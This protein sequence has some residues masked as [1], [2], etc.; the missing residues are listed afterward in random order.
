MFR[1]CGT[2]GC[3]KRDFHKGL[4][5]FEEEAVVEGRSSRYTTGR[6][7][8]VAAPGSSAVDKDVLN[9]EGAVVPF[10]GPVQPAWLVG[11]PY[12]CLKTKAAVE[13]EDDVE[14]VEDEDDEE[15]VEEV[16]EV[17][18]VEEVEANILS[19]DALAALQA[20]AADG[21]E[22]QRSSCLAGYLGVHVSWEPDCT[23][24]ARE[25]NTFLPGKFGT[26]EEAALARARH[27]RKRKNA[28]SQGQ[29][30]P[31]K[32][33]HAPSKQSSVEFGGH[34]ADP[35]LPEKRPRT[36]PLYG[37]GQAKQKAQ[38]LMNASTF[39]SFARN[40]MKKRE[41][42]TGLI[43]GVTWDTRGVTPVLSLTTAHANGLDSRWW[44]G[45]VCSG[46][47]RSRRRGMRAL[48]VSST[49]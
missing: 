20:A 49:Q 48:F 17:V 25:G 4:C 15:E 29:H 35:E 11:L 19:P 32:A 12:R 21:L 38:S 16:E 39:L 40:L 30:A 26:A 28:A 9:A 23:Y 5:S 7:L 43:P 34:T 27:F 10:K 45:C 44:Q 31:S 47:L 46:R 41:S 14:D 3:T 37:A 2:P 1:K 42:A 24:R 36:E 33:Q 6:C 18:E 8:D 22:L 13:E